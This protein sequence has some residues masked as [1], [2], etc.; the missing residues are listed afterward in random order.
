MDR[1]LKDQVSEWPEGYFERL[2]D[3]DE[4]APLERGSQGEF[5]SRMQLE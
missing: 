2:F 3:R 1:E 5:E 4:I